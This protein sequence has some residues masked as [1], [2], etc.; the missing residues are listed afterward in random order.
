MTWIDAAILFA[1]LL[2]RSDR[3][4]EADAHEARLRALPSSDLPEVDVFIATYN[5]PQDV[6]ERTIAGAMALDWPSERLHV[7]I[8]DDGRRDWL[9]REAEMRGIG[10]LTRTD[11]KG[12]K[13]GNIN[14]AVLRT[15]APFFLVLDADFVPQQRFLYRAMGFF[16]DPG[17]G[18]VQM[19]HN[20]FNSDPMQAALNMGKAMPDDQRFFFEEIMPGRDG[21]DCAF[22]CGSNG[23]VRRRALERI[24]NALPEGSV[25][26]DMLLTMAL[27]R[28]GYV[29]RYLNER[30]AFG[31]APE[32]INAFFVQRARW[33]RGAIQILFL[34]EG[35][36]GRSGLA[37]HERL[38]FLPTHWIT[39]SLGQIAAM[40]TPAFFMLTGIP[41]LL[42]TTVGGILGY[43]IPAVVATVA[44]V[45]LFAPGAYHPL[46]ALVL[47]TL[48]A[49][50]LLPVV[51]STLLKPHGHAFKV[52]PKGHTGQA[53][54]DGVTVRL[55][56]G[57][58]GLTSLGMF[59]NAIPGI[60]IVP[61]SSL[62]PVVTFW[63]VLNTIVLIL[64]AKVA[65]TPPA[66]RQEERFD[67]REPM[68]LVCPRF[69]AEV[70]GRDLSLSG[71]MVRADG[72]LGLQPG[73]WAGLEIPRVGLV[74][75]R[76]MR[77]ERD[78]RIGLSFVLPGY[79]ERR[80]QWETTN[81]RASRRAAEAPVSILTDAGPLPARMTD[82]SVT[83]AGL[84][85]DAATAPARD[86]WILLEVDD[87]QRIPGHVVRRTQTM[88]GTIAIGVE[89]FL[90]DLDL[91][92]RLVRMLFT[93]GRL[94][95]RVTN[96][97]GWA[98][99]WQMLR[100]GVA[101]DQE[102]PTV[103]VPSSHRAEI[104]PDWLRIRMVS[105]I[106]ASPERRDDQVA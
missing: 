41:P 69:E 62:V 52:T 12:A 49:F 95:R 71:A 90:V 26:E 94:N 106:A 74:P 11:N 72:P 14:A 68:R 39:Q 27:K 101:A 31:L 42:N 30:L 73:D 54:Q 66:Q 4:S 67:F 63:G 70:D 86:D 13:A 89:F 79:G 77:A 88:D 10:Y 35:P 100:Q 59:V 56:L 40:A 1:F 5:E 7:W 20:F 34:K 17:I 24:G 22:C 46:S 25:T 85:M 19:P 38:F 103:K 84:V 104:I 44:A 92:D 60:Q 53:D 6:L 29:T 61:F 98:I 96:D 91:R 83:G 33:A 102:A 76:V 81:R 65:T 99:F 36:L 16:D 80:A 8:L 32:G 45:R 15:S 75:A 9:R 97:K 23:I 2:R 64:V 48:Q 3:S 105:D 21:Y 18:I 87:G 47:S 51:L 50:R 43:Q 37:W 93:E 28:E 58:A 78:G 57:L 82:I 55:A